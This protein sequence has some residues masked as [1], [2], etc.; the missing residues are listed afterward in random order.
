MPVKSK[1]LT[2]EKIKS[3]ED[4]LHI[5]RSDFEAMKV[6]G[7]ALEQNVFTAEIRRDFFQKL[8]DKVEEQNN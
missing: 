8:I 3:S 1:K 2:I 7:S 4:R 6:F 5:L